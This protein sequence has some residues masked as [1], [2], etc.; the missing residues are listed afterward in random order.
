[1]DKKI[2]YFA[3]SAIT[4]FRAPYS[5]SSVVKSFAR[6]VKTIALRTNAHFVGRRTSSEEQAKFSRTCWKTRPL[7]TKTKDAKNLFEF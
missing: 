2:S 4:Y 7:D 3:S 1:M 5:A 6:A